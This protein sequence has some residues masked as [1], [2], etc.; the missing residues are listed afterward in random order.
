MEKP[1]EI[2]RRLHCAFVL[3]E[4]EGGGRRGSKVIKEKNLDDNQVITTKDVYPPKVA[5]QMWGIFGAEATNLGYTL[6]NGI[7]EEE[8]GNFQADPGTG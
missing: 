1:E 3:A 4:H 6:P 5:C 7:T 8:C 2:R